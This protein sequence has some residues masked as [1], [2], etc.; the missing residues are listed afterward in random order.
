MNELKR[1]EKD[2]QLLAKD[3]KSNT[4]TC[5]GGVREYKEC[6]KSPTKELQLTNASSLQMVFKSLLSSLRKHVRAHTGTHVHKSKE[7]STPLPWELLQGS[8]NLEILD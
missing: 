3:T 4:Q 7:P 6:M 2:W 8:F 1:K 5:F